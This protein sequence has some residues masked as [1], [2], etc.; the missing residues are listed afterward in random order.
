MFATTNSNPSDDKFNLREMTRSSAIALDGLIHFT[1]Q[2]KSAPP[3]KATM[4]I[5]N[6]AIS[7][8][9]K[10]C[11]EVFFFGVNYIRD[12]TVRYKASPDAE[13]IVHWVTSPAVQYCTSALNFFKAA[14]LENPSTKDGS[15]V[16]ISFNLLYTLRVEVGPSIA[17][18]EQ[19]VLTLSELLTTELLT[20]LAADAC[21]AV[22]S[23]ISLLI[24]S[25]QKFLR[26]EVIA[27]AHEYVVTFSENAH[28]VTE[29]HEALT[30]DESAFMQSVM[31]LTVSLGQRSHVQEFLVNKLFSK[32]GFLVIIQ[33]EIVSKISN[34]M[35]VFASIRCLALTLG[36]SLLLLE[37]AGDQA[38]EE[39]Q[40][41][42]LL[43]YLQSSSVIS[44]VKSK[45]PSFFD[46]I[47]IEMLEELFTFCTSQESG[48]T[49]A[50][51]ALILALIALA[52]SLAKRFGKSRSM[53]AASVIETVRKW[54]LTATLSPDWLVAAS[55]LALIRYLCEATGSPV[56]SIL[57]AES[58]RSCIRAMKSSSPD[59]SK[60]Q[61]F[62]FM[63]MCSNTG[64]LDIGESDIEILKVFI[65]EF[66]F[67]PEMMRADVLKKAYFR[68]ISMKDALIRLLSEFRREDIAFEDVFVASRVLLQM[69]TAVK[70][71]N[72]LVDFQHELVRM[73]LE[74]SKKSA[75]KSSILVGFVRAF[76]L[77]IVNKDEA[78]CEVVANV[79]SDLFPERPSN[80]VET[81]L[82]GIE[83]P[84]T[85]STIKSVL[86]NS[87]GSKYKPPSVSLTLDEEKVLLDCVTE[88]LRAGMVIA[89]D[90]QVAAAQ[91]T[92]KPE[93][94]SKEPQEG[95]GWLDSAA[96]WLIENADLDEVDEE[97]QDENKA[98]I[99]ESKPDE[100]SES[101]SEQE[102]PP[103]APKEVPKVKAPVVKTAAAPPMKALPKPT[104]QVAAKVAAKP[105]VAVKPASKPVPGKAPAAAAP[106]TAVAK[107]PPKPAAPLKAKAPPPAATPPSAKASTQAVPA[108]EESKEKKKKKKKDDDGFGLE[109]YVPD[110][111]AF[112]TAVGGWFGGA[113]ELVKEKKKKKKESSED[114]KSPPSPPKK[115]PPKAPTGGVGTVPKAVAGKPP[116]PVKKPAAAPPA[117]AVKKPAVPVKK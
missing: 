12:C 42:G 113:E 41:G 68:A 8:H 18:P 21:A 82:A 20:D 66:N 85:K 104:A 58:L 13:A 43:S 69:L 93:E 79:I 107:G 60:Q 16:T 9:G 62:A 109:A 22:L 40:S 59:F 111:G 25:N 28:S 95:G 55:G 19:L 4:E 64:Y 71:K 15:L 117:A 51:S 37:K 73:E 39:D 101:E 110:T 33:K 116:P 78:T 76:Q 61:A 96:N 1:G 77:A 75:S 84:G 23:A 108:E 24:S 50:D 100:S 89:L 80:F 65:A 115:V 54:A 92:A 112:Y 46:A 26:K 99:K 114:E 87:A 14:K 74:R 56:T 17:L 106:P 70:A 97:E 34:R 53:R 38:D 35:Y 11:P 32:S 47:D 36:Y 30:D 91:D 86:T 10:E 94:P 3:N 103:P 88:F 48:G 2:L 44:V 31:Y 57:S 27:F 29:P 5:V 83:N 98:P 90:E 105:A 81:L 102:A 45:I 67:H 52:V 49:E 7:V 72:S 6:T 63:Y